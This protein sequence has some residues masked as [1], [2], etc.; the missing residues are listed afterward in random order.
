[1]M[2]IMKMIK[3]MATVN[4]TGNQA[5]NTKETITKTNVKVTELWNGQMEVST[6]VIGKMVFNMV[7]VS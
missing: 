5:T 4:F 6:M 2:D 7:L 1:M 3:S